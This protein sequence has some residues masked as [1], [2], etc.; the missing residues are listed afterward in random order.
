MTDALTGLANRK[1][2]D[3]RFEHAV[4]EAKHGKPLTLALIDI[5]HFK[6]F[7]DT[8]GHQTGDQVLR[9]V[10]GVIGRMSEA[11]RFAARYG[12]EEFAILFPSEDA[13]AVTASLEQIRQ[14]IGSRSLKRR[15]TN[16]EL[17]AVTISC[18]LAQFR[19][20]ET[21]AQIT[22]R[23]DSAL[24]ASKHAG[25]NRVTSAEAASAHA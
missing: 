25:R 18:G 5:D 6:S 16:E 15:S 10:A 14:E 1:S 22:D 19:P 17:G 3:E 8:W 4:A 7:N 9:Y 20:G 11:P 23:A 24:Y 2:F 13:A 12:G 21:G